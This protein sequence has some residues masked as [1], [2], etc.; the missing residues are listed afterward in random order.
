M[1]PSKNSVYNMNEGNVNHKF[2]NP[3]TFP[4]LINVPLL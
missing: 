4:D 3:L 1:I 2:Y